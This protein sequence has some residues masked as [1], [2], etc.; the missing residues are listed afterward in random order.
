M[1]TRTRPMRPIL[2]IGVLSVAMAAIAVGQHLAGVTMPLVWRS[3]I[4]AVV[5]AVLIWL[6]LRYWDQIDVAAREAQ[7]SAWLWGGSAGMA[8]GFIAD[9]VLRQ[10][11]VAPLA[12]GLVW[13]LGGPY[14]VGGALVAFGAMIGFLIGWAIWWGSK[15]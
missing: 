2:W 9:G 8:A 7:K 14:L 6:L 1:S 15:R 10:P 12:H 11:Q 3:I 4:G 13:R 5:V